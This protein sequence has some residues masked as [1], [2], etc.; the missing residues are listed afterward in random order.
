RTHSSK[1][2]TER[3]AHDRRF[4]DRRVDHALAAE[5]MD[6]SFRDFERASIY[7]DVFAN[8]EDSGIAL[9]LFPNAFADCFDI[10][11]HIDCWLLAAGFWLAFRRSRLL[12]H[13]R[14]CATSLTAASLC[15]LLFLSFRPPYKNG[16]STVLSQNTRS[17]AVDPSG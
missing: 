16:I 8:T 7:A 2:R 3:C 10:G 17:A 4:G 12:I 6:E 1:R 13:H 9:H 11:G 14:K 15:F 5:V